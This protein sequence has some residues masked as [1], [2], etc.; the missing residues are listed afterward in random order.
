MAPLDCHTHSKS[1]SNVSQVLNTPPVV[2]AGLRRYKRMD[3]QRRHRAIPHATTGLTSS[4]HLLPGVKNHAF[5]AGNTLE[6]GFGECQG[7]NLCLNSK[8]LLWKTGQ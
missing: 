5:M 8:T 7:S 1:S 4:A 3:P 2:S 6:S